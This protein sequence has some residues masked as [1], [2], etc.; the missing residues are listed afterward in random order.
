VAPAVVDAAAGVVVGA[1]V[2]AV[3]TLVQKIRGK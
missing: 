1:V 2:L 3:V